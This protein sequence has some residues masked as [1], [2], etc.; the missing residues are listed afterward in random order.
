MIAIWCSMTSRYSGFT[1]FNRS[2]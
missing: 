1:W 2:Y